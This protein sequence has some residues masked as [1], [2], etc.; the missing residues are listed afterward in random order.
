VSAY[1]LRELVDDVTGVVRATA[2]D[3]ERCERITPFLKRWMDGGGSLPEKYAQPCDGGACGHLLYTDPEGAYFII[4]VVFP[5][6]TSSGVHYHGAWGVIGILQGIDEETK[7]AR[8]T[9]PDEIGIG[10]PCELRQTDKIYSPVGTITY[11]R[12]PLEGFHRVRAAGE[13]TG[14]SLHILGGTPDTHPHFFCNGETKTLV[15]F[16]MAGI[17]THE[18]LIR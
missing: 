7:Y 9:S 12:P 17:I 8:D 6:G 1:G 16:P 15:D 13:E 4:S 11:L 14:V 18:P 3:N 5:A 10:E 2:D